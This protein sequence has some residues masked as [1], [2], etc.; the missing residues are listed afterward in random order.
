[1]T[2][3][4]LFDIYWILFIHIGQIML[5]LKLVLTEETQEKVQDEN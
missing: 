2:S 4:P 5:S 3:A 1:M